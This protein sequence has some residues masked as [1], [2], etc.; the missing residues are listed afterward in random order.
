MGAKE[1]EEEKKEEAAAEEPEEE[2]KE[3]PPPKVQLS[4]DEKKISFRDRVIKDLEPASFSASFPKFSLPDKAEGFDEI[5]FEWMKTEKTAADFLRDWI[6]GKKLVT[7]IEDIK[8]SPWFTTKRKDWDLAVKKFRDSLTSYKAA[9]AKKEAL[10]KTKKLKK[11]AAQ[12][13]KEA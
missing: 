7:R 6:L 11:I 3:E 2:E 5:K 9:I 8:P 13:K 1:G 12:K 4:A 10:K